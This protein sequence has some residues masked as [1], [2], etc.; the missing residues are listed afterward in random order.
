MTKMRLIALL[1]GGLA[2]R[3][4]LHTLKVPKAYS[5]LHLRRR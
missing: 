4:W 5:R 2:L 3:L 1:T